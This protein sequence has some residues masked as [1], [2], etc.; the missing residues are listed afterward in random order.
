MDD[1]IEI[2]KHNQPAKSVDKFKFNNLVEFTQEQA[3]FIA[4]KHKPDPQQQQQLPQKQQE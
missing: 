1:C 3:K 2:L 4:A